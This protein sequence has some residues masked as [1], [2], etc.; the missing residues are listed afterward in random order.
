MSRIAQALL[1]LVVLSCLEA[2]V[3]LPPAVAQPAPNPAAEAGSTD[4]I[5]YTLRPGDSLW[6]LSRRFGV[7]M[8]ELAV[9]NGIGNA[10]RLRAGDVIVIPSAEAE[11]EEAEA[12][13]L[14][15]DVHVVARGDSLYSIARLYGVSAAELRKENGIRNPRRLQL[16]QQLRIPAARRAD[17]APHPPAPEED[18]A[19][20][21]DRTPRERQPQATP[22]R[23]QPKVHVV[24]RGDSLYE[25][26]RRYGV[27]AAEL[28]KENGIRDPRRLQLGQRLR[29]PSVRHAE[30]APESQ[31]E[32]TADAAPVPAP[33][34]QQAQT[35]RAPSARERRDRLPW[36]KVPDEASDVPLYA[37]KPDL[38]VDIALDGPSVHRLLTGRVD[39]RADFE[40]V[41][42]R[43]PELGRVLD[44]LPMRR[45]VRVRQARGAFLAGASLA[46]L[47][48]SEE[49]VASFERAY[50]VDP[51]LE[52]DPSLTS[53]RLS[54][55]LDAARGAGAR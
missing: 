46:G 24:A 21:P 26:A 1:A 7:S 41:L 14:P 54:E 18:A 47:G 39:L 44:R 11:S 29:I 35:A 10:R 31:R 5:R 9:R 27:S 22:S 52:L 20:E 45:K 8:R 13:D 17:A 43:M 23:P 50:E 37:R 15:P 28:K 33:G 32:L 48:R 6:T 3:L 34:A 12:P 4:G 40:A 19:A 16:G 42:Q 36:K 30:A 49:A 2:A 25:L 51:D 53:P 38:Q 55:L